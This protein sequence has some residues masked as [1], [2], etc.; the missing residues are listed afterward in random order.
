MTLTT[1]PFELVLRTFLFVLFAAVGLLAM[2]NAAHAQ[3][4]GLPMLVFGIYILLL[5]IALRPDRP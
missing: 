3:N 5:L 4:Y 1:L 2:R